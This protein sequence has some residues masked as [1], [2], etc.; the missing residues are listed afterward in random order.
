MTITYFSIVINLSFLGFKSGAVNVWVAFGRMRRHVRSCVVD[1][2]SAPDIQNITPL[3]I[4]FRKHR[5]GKSLISLSTLPINYLQFFLRE[6]VYYYM[7]NVAETLAYCMPD[8]QVAWQLGV[9]IAIRSI[10]TCL[11]LVLLLVFL[12]QM[13]MPM[14]IELSLTL[15]LLLYA[16][17]A[18]AYA[19]A[20]D[21]NA[22]A[23]MPN[24]ACHLAGVYASVAAANVVAVA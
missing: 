19:A 7:N 20:D 4:F 10:A 18:A 9:A 23:K 2:D 24:A 13:L 22:D 8:S 21:A 16:F 11:P 14:L 17:D 5:T 3:D 12:H 6:V 1:T 15:M